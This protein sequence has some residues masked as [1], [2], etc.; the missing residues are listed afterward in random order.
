MQNFSFYAPT[1]IH[2]GKGQVAQLASEIPAGARVLLVCGGG[3]I[4]RK[5]VNPDL[6]EERD[7]YTFDLLEFEKFFWTEEVYNYLKNRNE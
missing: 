7:K 3:S 5:I 1:R 4:K 6:Q 2:F